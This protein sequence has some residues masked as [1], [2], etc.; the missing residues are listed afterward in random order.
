MRAR[1][2]VVLPTTSFALTLVQVELILFF[3]ETMDSPDNPHLR[4][5]S[6]PA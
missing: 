1:L 6:R 4:S 2:L 5:Y 3:V